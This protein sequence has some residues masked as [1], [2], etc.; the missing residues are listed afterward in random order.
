LDLVNH[1]R[2]DWIVPRV[3]A[4]RNSVVIVRFAMTIQHGQHAV[5]VMST[6]CA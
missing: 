2:Q 3:L 5:D 1:A 6:N 4:R